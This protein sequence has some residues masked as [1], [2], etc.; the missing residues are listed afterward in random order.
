MIEKD[1]ID[2]FF[3]ER[4]NGDEPVFRE[5]YWQGLEKMLDSIPPSNPP[6][7]P[8]GIGKLLRFLGSG[9]GIIAMVSVISM[10]AIITFTLLSE[11]EPA[12]NTQHRSAAN[13]PFVSH[14]AEETV[15]RNAL[16][17]WMNTARDQEDMLISSGAHPVN[18]PGSTGHTATG[19]RTEWNPAADAIHQRSTGELSGESILIN[20]KISREA[21]GDATAASATHVIDNGTFAASQAV[22]FDQQIS[23]G[24]T[25][26][27]GGT[28]QSVQP[29]QEPA[30][31]NQIENSFTAG[32][33]AKDAKSDKGD[34]SGWETD[35]KQA[36]LI[37]ATADSIRE[38]VNK[39]T[40]TVQDSTVPVR[41]L[42]EDSPGRERDSEAFK[43]SPF[44]LFISPGVT[45][46]KPLG[47]IDGFRDRTKA[48][49][50]FGAGMEYAVSERFSILLEADFLR[51]SGNRLQRSV[52]ESS[53]LF[54][55]W[56]TITILENREMNLLFLPLVVRFRS[57]DHAVGAGP[58]LGFL[59]STSGEITLKDSTPLLTSFHHERAVNYMEGLNT[60]TGGFSLEYS[61]CFYRNHA[62]LVRYQRTTG[63]WTDPAT[64]GELS[65][66][67]KG[68]LQIA[69][70]FNVL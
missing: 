40:T 31:A 12:T 9:K 51:T 60:L 46:Y 68:Y 44:R 18:K 64:Y 57:G 15:D 36:E 69:L 56:T 63:E 32:V 38:T 67:P 16:R 2:D 62:I 20:T 4:L 26:V 21:A 55:P 6:F 17:L 33:T 8:S 61:W 24:E 35:H 23:K 53:I 14:A 25:G 19:F 10:S 48:A 49:F 70:Q 29:K 42:N 27:S 58:M 5:E 39:K 7:T 50:H 1:N 47:N 28:E 43:Q 3:R 41:Q 66:S 59:L 37:S 54:Y 34:N 13:I 11:K 52:S 30:E 65:K 45:V 22:A